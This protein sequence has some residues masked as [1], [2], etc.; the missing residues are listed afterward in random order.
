[1]EDMWK[2]CR[3]AV[4]DDLIVDYQVRFAPSQFVDIVLK[5]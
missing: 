2:A 1:M 3:Y 4:S 5:I